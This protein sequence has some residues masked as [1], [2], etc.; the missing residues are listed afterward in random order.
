M[1]T[2]LQLCADLVR[3][4]GG[5]G[6]APAS[7]IGQ[8]GRQEKIVGWVRTAWVLIQNLHPHWSFLRGEFTGTLVP[9]A[10]TYTGA[11]FNVSRFGGWIG[12]RAGFEPLSLYDPAV[13]RTDEA[14]IR[15][16]T[17]DAWRQRWD[18]GVHDDGRPIDYTIAP[19]GTIRFGPAPDLAYAIRGEYRKSPQ[20]LAANEDVP[21]MPEQYHD[22]IVWRAIKLM[23]DSDEAIA[24]LNL[25]NDKYLEQKATMERDLL[26]E[27]SARSLRPLA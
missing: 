10:A 8:A 5:S 3:E 22:I 27:F 4:S 9:G 6:R 7:V 18:R 11:S 24:A 14:P 1:A 12:G 21:D 15:Q 20:R 19:D 16:I 26:P 23:A 13:G 2:F 17:Y 25:A